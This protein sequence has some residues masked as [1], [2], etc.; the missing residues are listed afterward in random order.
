MLIRY[1]IGSDFHTAY[2][3]PG[4]AAEH[5]EKLK[6]IGA[7]HISVWQTACGCNA[8][9]RADSDGDEFPCEDCSLGRQYYEMHNPD[10]VY[11]F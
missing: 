10:K 8:G 1:M 7:K 11:P 5:I 9:W 3:Y 4:S 2:L 6:S